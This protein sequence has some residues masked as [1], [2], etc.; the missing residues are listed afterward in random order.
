M[1]PTNRYIALDVFR[2]LTIC[3]MII[4]NTPGNHDTIYAPLQ[5]A[6]WHGFTPAD[7]VYPSFLFAVGN[8]LCFAVRKWESITQAQV[9][10]RIFKR[11]LV[12]FILGFL[13][14]WFPFV[15]KEESGIVFKSFS[16]T[17]ILGVLQRIALCYC[18]A[19]LLVYYFK[20]AGAFITAVFLLIAYQ[21]ILF[22]FGVPGQELT[23][24]G[25]AGTRL[26]VWLLGASHLNHTEAIPFEAEGLLGTL[27]A[28]VNVIAGYLTGRYIQQTGKTARMLMRLA[29]AGCG[30]TAL[31]LVWNIWFP[32]NKNLWTSS[33][34]LLTVG[35]DC[36]ILAGVIYVIDFLRKDRWVYFFEVFGKNAL[37]IY[38]LS[39]VVAIML[40]AVHVYGW[41]YDHIFKFT[42]M[43]MG[44]L[45]FAIC[46]T[47]FCWLAGWYLDKRKI[48]IRV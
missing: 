24:A 45:L 13:L 21:L 4:V 37:F 1:I 25:N 22:W 19:S 41:I 42:G 10:A 35:L 6:A 20:P 31:A 32:I 46:F 39:E 36:I 43:Y 47:L 33:F 23:M 34:V 28:V 27:P 11:S 44:S 29:L 7:L 30:F 9:L 2:G 38:L 17:R 15:Q 48:Y 12:L 16:E 5:H 26:D 40:R 18:I 8:A 3:L 14:Y